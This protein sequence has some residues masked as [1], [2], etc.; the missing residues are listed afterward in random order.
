MKVDIEGSE[1]TALPQWIESGALD[2][3][4]LADF[5]ICSFW[6]QVRELASILLNFSIISLS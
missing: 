2:K 5:H 3:V 4:G 1:L 6:T